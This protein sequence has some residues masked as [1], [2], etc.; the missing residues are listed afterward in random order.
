[1]N[2]LCF[3]MIRVT[4]RFS[5]IFNIF[6]LTFF[7]LW[8]FTLD[9]YILHIFE[10][11]MSIVLE[12]YVLSW[13]STENWVLWFLWRRILAKSIWSNWRFWLLLWL[14]LKDI[15]LYWL[16]WAFV[17]LLD[18]LGNS[19]FHRS[20]W[21][22]FTFFTRRSLWE[23]DFNWYYLLLIKYSFRFCLRLDRCFDCLF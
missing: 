6:N 13:L 16:L 7:N 3:N 21:F 1:M 12:I 8:F 5:W 23:I 19:L 15:G 17:D 10:V 22:R 11:N 18:F 4:S 14:F 9:Y 2:D 20:Y